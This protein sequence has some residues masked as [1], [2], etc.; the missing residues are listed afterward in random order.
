MPTATPIL[1]RFDFA[2]NRRGDGRFRP[3]WGRR[4]GVLAVVELF[5]PVGEPDVGAQAVERLVGSVKPF[6]NRAGPRRTLACCSLS[7]RAKGG[8]EQA[9]G[10][11]EAVVAVK[12]FGDGQ[13][14]FEQVEGADKDGHFGHSQVTSNECRVTNFGPGRKRPMGAVRGERCGFPASVWPV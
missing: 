12:M 4:A 3:A 14:P 7:L 10:E 5:E 1:N 11:G 8:V 6:E 13:Q 9:T 2:N